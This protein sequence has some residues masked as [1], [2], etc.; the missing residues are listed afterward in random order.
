LKR[1]AGAAS[2]AIKVSEEKHPE[3]D[4]NVVELKGRT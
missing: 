1:V 3:G 2:N 4:G